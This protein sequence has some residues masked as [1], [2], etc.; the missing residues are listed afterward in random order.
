MKLAL[1]FLLVSFRAEAG[2]AACDKVMSQRDLNQCAVMSAKVADASLE[3]FYRSYEKRLSA[4]Q[5][6]LFHSANSGWLNYRKAYC[7]FESSGVEGGSV[8]PFI[9]A[10]CMTEQSKN[11]LKEMQELSR[12]K[13][14]DLSCPAWQASEPNKSF[15][16]NPRRSFKT[17][18]GSSSGSA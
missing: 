9:F 5:I 16:P 17:P 6:E 8:Y 1:L 7:V 14:G 11:R 3:K 10:N 15:K 12:C 2:V 4:E 13:E 18:S